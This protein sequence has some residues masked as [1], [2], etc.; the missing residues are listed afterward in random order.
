MSDDHFHS[1]IPCRLACEPLA[2][3]IARRRAAPLAGRGAHP[4]A[5]PSGRLQRS[6]ARRLLAGHGT[7]HR[8]SDRQRSSPARRAAQMNQQPQHSSTNQIMGSYY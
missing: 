5:H 8:T 7:R 6:P 1:V 2:G 4:R 3:R